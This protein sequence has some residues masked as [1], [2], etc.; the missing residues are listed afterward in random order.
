MGFISQS[1]HWTP[2]KYLIRYIIVSRTVSI[3]SC[4]NASCNI[5]RICFYGNEM[6]TCLI[7]DQ[8]NDKK[9]CQFWAK[10]RFLKVGSYLGKLAKPKFG[11]MYRELDSMSELS[12]F[13]YIKSHVT[14]HVKSKAQKVNCYHVLSVRA[15]CFLWQPVMRVW[16]RS[17]G[18]NTPK[19]LT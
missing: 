9:R 1:T 13:V 8:L 6:T 17:E 10:K 14:L 3:F 12:G 16:Q 2:W 18:K 5:L 15:G 4:H 11:H 19:E 7:N